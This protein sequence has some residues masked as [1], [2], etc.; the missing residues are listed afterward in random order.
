M[1][2]S[3]RDFSEKGERL[4]ERLCR[5]LDLPPD[6]L[7]RECLTELRGRGSVT[8][9]GGV[10]ILTYTEE[11]IRLG[12]SFGILRV[13]GAGLSCVAFSSDSIRIDGRVRG[14]ILEEDEA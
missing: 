4:R 5:A 11:L 3:K 9:S 6:G 8:V 7:L 12:V 2:R 14:L 10:E 1:P 13:E